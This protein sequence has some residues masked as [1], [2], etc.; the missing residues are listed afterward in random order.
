MAKINIIVTW[1]VW[2][3]VAIVNSFNFDVRSI[4]IWI[5]TMTIIY[6]SLALY[7]KEK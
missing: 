4:I 7:G 6:F 2:L 1:I 5:A 3:I